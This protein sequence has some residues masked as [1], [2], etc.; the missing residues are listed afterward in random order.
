MK[1]FILAV[2]CVAATDPTNEA[3][4]KDPALVKFLMSDENKNNWNL[5]MDYSMKEV[6]LDQY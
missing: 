6:M 4:E 2:A 3:W 5:H 1:I